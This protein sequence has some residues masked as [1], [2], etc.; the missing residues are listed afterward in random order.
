MRSDYRNEITQTWNISKAYITLRF[1]CTL[2]FAVILTLSPVNLHM[3]ILV[4]L[5]ALQINLK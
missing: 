2:L 4:D 1:Y 3:E 5:H